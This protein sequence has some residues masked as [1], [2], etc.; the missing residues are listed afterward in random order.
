MSYMH[1]I[2]FD[3]VCAIQWGT[4]ILNYHHTYSLR[5]SKGSRF[6]QDFG[7]TLGI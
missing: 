4:L 1:P 6:R 5:I 3:I 2:E 7:Q